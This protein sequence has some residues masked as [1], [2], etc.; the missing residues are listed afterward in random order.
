MKVQDVPNPQ[1][2]KGL[3]VED[4]AGILNPALLQSIDQIARQ[5]ESKTGVELAVVTLDSL[6][7][8]SIEDFAEKLFKRFGIGKKAK[9]NGILILLSPSDRKVRIEVGY[10]LEPVL[11]DAVS[12]RLINEFG[13]PRF[14]QGQYAQGL[15]D[16]EREVA[17]KVAAAQGQQMSFGEAPITAESTP[18]NLPPSELSNTAPEVSE[19]SPWALWLLWWIFPGL[20]GA[21]FLFR[22]TQYFGTKA[23]AARRAAAGKFTSIFV[24]FG[25]AEGGTSYFL[26]D[27]FPGIRFL[28]GFLLPT[29]I[30][31]GSILGI[32]AW[33]RRRLKSYHVNCAQCHVPMSLID[34]RSDD[35]FLS[36]EE[37]AEEKA[38]G[39][40][41]EFWRCPSCQHLERFNVKLAGASPCSKCGRRTLVYA[42]SVISSATTMSS[43]LRR[44]TETCENPKCGFTRTWTTVIP[45][46]SSSS[47]SGGSSSSSGSFGGGSSGGGGASG[48]W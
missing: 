40:D 44:N 36:V 31:A 38:K 34:E 9:D 35:E 27:V 32:G 33:L 22:I 24:L 39:M 48:S 1:T 19:R 45:R 42:S 14:K 28:S 13:I 4:A 6:D 41:Y 16:L 17:S 11:T 2:T 8:I 20:A 15:F 3:Y 47:S 12:K 18:E 26:R 23:L 25:V 43:G 10:G 30:A 21:M 7:G 29:L 37:K 46:V 5:L